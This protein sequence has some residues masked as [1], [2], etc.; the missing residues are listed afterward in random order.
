M[1]DDSDEVDVCR[2]DPTGANWS[3]TGSAGEVEGMDEI[4][5]EMLHMILK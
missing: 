2:S 1:S 4:E 5:A 3:V